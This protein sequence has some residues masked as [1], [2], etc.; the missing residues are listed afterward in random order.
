M[1]STTDLRIPMELIIQN[2]R[3]HL[4]S[5][6]CEVR[7]LRSEPSRPVSY[8]RHPACY[9]YYYTHTDHFV[10]VRAV[11]DLASLSKTTRRMIKQDLERDL[12]LYDRAAFEATEAYRVQSGGAPIDLRWLVLYRRMHYC[13]ICYR[14]ADEI[15]RIEK[16]RFAVQESWWML[17]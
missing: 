4:Y 10:Y 17:S 11:R 5:I 12:V 1:K 7:D 6:M 2:L 13:K 16:C 3:E 15:D 9:N 8:Q 14:M